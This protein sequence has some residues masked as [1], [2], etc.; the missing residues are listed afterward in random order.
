MG[1]MHSG[2]E[3][4]LVRAENDYLSHYYFCLFNLL[5]NFGMTNIESPDLGLLKTEGPRVRASSASLRCGP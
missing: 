4:L 1:Q 3:G 5:G 2:G